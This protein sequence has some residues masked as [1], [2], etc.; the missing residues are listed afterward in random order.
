MLFRSIPEQLYVGGLLLYERDIDRHILKILHLRK[1]GEPEI[2]RNALLLSKD[3]D[4]LIEGGII[5]PSEDDPI[6][7]KRL[8]RVGEGPLRFLQIKL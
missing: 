5:R 3:T 4:S 1:H 2:G 6:R 7:P 8:N